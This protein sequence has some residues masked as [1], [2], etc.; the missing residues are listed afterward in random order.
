MKQ[1]L[2]LNQIYC[3]DCLEGLRQI[4]DETI[5]LAIVDPPFGPFCTYDTRCTYETWL[6]EKNRKAGK[7][8]DSLGAEAK[9]TDSVELAETAVEGVEE[10]GEVE[11][12]EDASAEDVSMEGAS[13]E[14]VSAEDADVLE[15]AEVDSE[16]PARSEGGNAGRRLSGRK[17]TAAYLR[18]AKELL[19][20]VHR[21]LTPDGTLWLAMDD[22]F[23]AEFKLMM[24]EELHFHCENW[25]VW[26]YMYGTPSRRKFSLSHT[27]LFQMTKNPKEF[28]FNADDAKVRV[29]TA[30]EELYHD[31]RA[32]PNGKVP[33]N[34]WLYQR[35]SG[36]F[37]NSRDWHGC[38]MP[39]L[40][41]GR[42]IRTTSNLEDVVLDPFAGNGAVLAVAKKLGRRYIGFELSPEYCARANRR[43]QVSDYG[44]P[45]EGDAIKDYMK[46]MFEDIP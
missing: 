8:S 42:I 29:P 6:V 19:A 28:T 20:E 30:R 7:A 33:D 5:P 39:E 41:L 10:A 26:Y 2:A 43:V 36:T 11:D 44:D 9:D 17:A 25:V 45:L 13:A 18:W 37:R 46:K 24:Q 35:S 3:Q 40:L 21:V 22:A 23:A 34:T 14:D 38:R 12:A 27:H 32:N 4:A 31:K 1:G 16:E 15:S